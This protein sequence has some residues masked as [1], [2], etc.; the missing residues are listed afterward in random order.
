[1]R[2]GFGAAA[3]RV[4]SSRVD[5]E[6]HAVPEAL[7]TCHRALK[8]ERK[9]ERRLTGKALFSLLHLP[10]RLFKGL[11]VCIRT[12]DEFIPLL[13]HHR[14]FMLLGYLGCSWLKM[15][16]LSFGLLNQHS[17]NTHCVQSPEPSS[18]KERRN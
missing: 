6:N 12:P 13:T 15:Q 11:L 14:V 2:L 16:S 5:A 8:G 1:M 3:S 9:R 18:K 7:A 4:H 17:F 10:L